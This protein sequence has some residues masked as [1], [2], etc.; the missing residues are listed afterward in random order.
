MLYPNTFSAR[1]GFFWAKLWGKFEAEGI[2]R[3]CKGIVF[4]HP[5]ISNMDVFSFLA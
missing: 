1:P 5:S 4:W 3:L 2:Y